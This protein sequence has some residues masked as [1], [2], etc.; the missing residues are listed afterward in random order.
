MD[1]HTYPKV[2]SECGQNRT[3]GTY[4][5]VQHVNIRPSV[6]FCHEHRETLRTEKTN[7]GSIRYCGVQNKTMCPTKRIYK[8][9]I[10]VLLE[11]KSDEKRTAVGG[12]VLR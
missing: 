4:F 12:S 5:T 6:K 8:M 2:E 11:I 3:F 10:R 9:S 7:R 1:L